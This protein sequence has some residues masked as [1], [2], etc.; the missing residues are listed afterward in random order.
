M[1]GC[2][3]RDEESIIIVLF[4]TLVLIVGVYSYMGNISTINYHFD[5]TGDI[6]EWDNDTKEIIVE[7]VFPQKFN[8]TLVNGTTEVTFYKGSIGVL[9]N[10]FVVNETHDGNLVVH[11]KA[12]LPEEPTRIEFDIHYA[13]MVD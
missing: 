13:D 7:Q 2:E 6:S 8:E 10:I 3:N 5:K 1:L 11:A 9:D 4:F 12:K